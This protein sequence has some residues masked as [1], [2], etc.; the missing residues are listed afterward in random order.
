MG[1]PF[2][3]HL[4]RVSRLCN[5]ILLVITEIRYS[6]EPPPYR[7]EYLIA[8]LKLSSQWGME[9]GR[10]WA[11]GHITELGYRCDPALRLRLAR[12]YNVDE[13]VMPA[14]RLLLSLTLPLVALRNVSSQWLSYPEYE[15]IA[16]SKEGLEKERKMLALFPLRLDTTNDP[17]GELKGADCV[18]HGECA[19]IWKK[20]WKKYIGEPMLHPDSLFAYTFDDAKEKMEGHEFNGMTKSCRDL[21]IRKVLDSG[22]FDILE[23]Y[24][25]RAYTRLRDQVPLQI[26]DIQVD[27]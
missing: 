10:S 15:L 5:I 19:R 25:K 12:Q 1:L 14:L 27:E 4:R 17:R 8:V 11:I 13:W 2:K 3:A 18:S 9:G 21:C 7:L 16:C 26:L 6:F 23:T 20:Q 22:V 24:A